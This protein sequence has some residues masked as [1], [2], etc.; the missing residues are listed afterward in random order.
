MQIGEAQQMS[1]KAK[2][3]SEERIGSKEKEEN[4]ALLRKSAMALLHS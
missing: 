3:P 2:M 1:G 4:S